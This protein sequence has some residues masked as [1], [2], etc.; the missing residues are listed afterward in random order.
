MIVKY[1]GKDDK[2]DKQIH[3]EV[4]FQIDYVC[5]YYQID[6]LTLKFI[7]YFLHQDIVTT[8]SPYIVLTK[9]TEVKRR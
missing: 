6:D 2:S 1:E 4:K 9:K 8:T 7:C 3:L 5:Q